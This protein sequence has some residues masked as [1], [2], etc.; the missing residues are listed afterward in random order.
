MCLHRNLFLGFMSLLTTSCTNIDCP[1]GNVVTI[2]GGLYDAETKKSYKLADTLTVSVSGLKD[3]IL[4]NRAL[5]ISSI[6]LPLKYVAQEDTLLF[7]FSNAKNQTATDTLFIQHKAQPHFES[8][9]CPTV[10]FHTI[11]NIRWT[12]HAMR[13]MP[14]TIDSVSVTNKMVNYDNVENIKIYLR[15]LVY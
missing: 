15:S 4:L 8:I 7:C 11:E 3:T 6:S 2:N 13:Q 12:K 5:N 1:L 9:D 10:V 14:L